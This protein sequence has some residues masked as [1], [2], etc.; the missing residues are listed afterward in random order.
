MSGIYEK[1]A[2]CTLQT[3]LI[4]LSLFQEQPD[5]S[6]DFFSLGCFFKNLYKEILKK[7]IDLP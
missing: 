2:E 3:G 4:T 6:L 7:I 1:K 5:R